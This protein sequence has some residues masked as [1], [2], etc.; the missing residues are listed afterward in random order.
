M[1]DVSLVDI[2]DDYILRI[3]FFFFFFSLSLSLDICSLQINKI[4][5]LRSRAEKL[6][7]FGDIVSVNEYVRL[8][9]R[10]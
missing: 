5:S 3:F 8:E 9:A 6:D 4:D 7:L 10:R 1:F 2:N